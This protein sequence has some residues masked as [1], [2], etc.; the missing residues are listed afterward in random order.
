MKIRIDESEFQG[1]G[2]K[3]HTIYRVKGHDSLGDI[4][5]RRRYNEF[6]LFRDMLFSRYPGLYIPAIPPKQ[7]NGNKAEF[8]IEERKYFLD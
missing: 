4:D 2:L 3:K 6:Y 7:A 1:S 8:F 5:V